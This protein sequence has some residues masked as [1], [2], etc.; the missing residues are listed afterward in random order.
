MLIDVGLENISSIN[1][2]VNKSNILI[3][4]ISQQNRLIIF[5]PLKHKIKRLNKLSP[6]TNPQNNLGL[7]T[8]IHY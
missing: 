2:S 7:H 4:S 8:A 1:T 6:L 5:V 3:V